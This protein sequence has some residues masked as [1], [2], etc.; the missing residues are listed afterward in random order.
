MAY[1]DLSTLTEKQKKIYRSLVKAKNIAEIA[2]ENGVSESAIQLL[3]RIVY[4]KIGVKNQEQ[5][6]LNNW[7]RVK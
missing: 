5:L 1:I 6:I 4:A 2:N 3:A 7:E